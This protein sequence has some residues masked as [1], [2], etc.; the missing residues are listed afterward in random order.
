[1]P[2]GKF[3]KLVVVKLILIGFEQPGDYIFAILF[4][5]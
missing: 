5:I 2:P 1:M 4:K 3:G